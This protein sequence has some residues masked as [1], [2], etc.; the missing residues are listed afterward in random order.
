MPVDVTDR[1]EPTMLRCHLNLH[2]LPLRVSTPRVPT[3]LVLQGV[4]EYVYDKL[5]LL[6][7]LRCAYPAAAI[8]LSYAVGHRVGA[9]EAHGWVAPLTAANLHEMFETLGLTV[10]EQRRNCLAGQTCMRLTPR[11]IA[12]LHAEICAGWAPPDQRSNRRDSHTGHG[13]TDG[14]REVGD[15]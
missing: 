6:R 2:Q 5:L 10:S 11:P 1:G 15:P 9:N 8:L 7:A 4:F 12:S 13:V 14:S 3:V